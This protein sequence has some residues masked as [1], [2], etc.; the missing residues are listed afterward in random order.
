[1]IASEVAARF[2]SFS[3]TA[4][5]PF[6]HDPHLDLVELQLE[7]RIL[8]R[9]GGTRHVGLDDDV[10]G[11]LLAGLDRRGELLEGGRTAVGELLAALACG[12]AFGHVTR[13]P[14]GVDDAELVT[15]L[16]HVVEPDD[17][18]RTGRGGLVDL[19]PVLVE[20]GADLAV[21][22]A[23]HE[24]VPAL[25]RAAL[26]QDRGDGATSLVEVGL[27]HATAGVLVRVRL[28]LEQV[29]L[30]EHD[31]EQL[32]QADPGLG[33]HLDHRH[34]TTEVLGDDVV[35]GQLR[36]HPV[37][38]GGVEVDLVDRDDHRDAGRLDVGDG[39]LGLGH[40]AVVGGDH[41]DGDVGHLG[42]TGTHGGERLVT[43]GVDEGD[44][45]VV[46]GDLVRTDVLGDAARLARDHVG[47]TDRVEQQGLAVVDV[48]HDGDDRR[49]R[50]EGARVLRGLDPELELLLGEEVHLDTE[51][52]ADDLDGVVGQRLLDGGHLAHLE[53]LLDDRSPGHTELVGELA[54]RDA[55][56]HLD[57]GDLDLLLDRDVAAPRPTRELLL[58]RGLLLLLLLA[59]RLAAGGT[60]GTAT[61]PGTTGAAGA[62]TGSPSA[63][64]LAVGRARR[65]AWRTATA[66]WRAATTRG[67]TTPR[68]GAAAGG[69]TA[70]GGGTAG[71]RLRTC[72][73]L[74]QRWRD[75]PAAGAL[76][77]Q[78]LVSTTRRRDAL[79]GHGR[80]RRR[81][82]L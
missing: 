70:A 15:G 50:L 64:G 30:Q 19:L 38:V 78:P 25:E 79:A 80:G 10:E 44:P 18:H 6:C 29:G 67:A 43:R 40:H 1:M 48:A 42:T 57:A 28:Q 41:Q 68:R 21:G 76:L 47:Q 52:G 4:P 81:A 12:P 59:L 24:D 16:G 77:G 51:V 31:L 66:G 36:L 9:L 82:T 14:L 72:R 13:E 63:D 73:S 22:G 56:E 60:T 35:L 3:V 62:T 54:H 11:R 61:R 7:E 23:R 69:R 53:Q 49:A 46:L 2:T 58:L 27:D 45:P 39:L 71:L 8:E 32:V 20:H 26:D 55:R 75:R 5:T 37:R 34:V 65:T 17:L 74:P 33:G